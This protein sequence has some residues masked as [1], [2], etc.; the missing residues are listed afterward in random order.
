[1]S[2]SS[3]DL[4]AVQCL[5]CRADDAEPRFTKDGLEV[6]R[7]RRCHLLYVN[8]RLTAKALSR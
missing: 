5:L 7:C 6:V 3:S 8:P 4:E 1:M 2:F